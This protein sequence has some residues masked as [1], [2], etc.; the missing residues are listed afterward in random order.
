MRLALSEYTG[1]ENDIIGQ[2]SNEYPDKSANPHTRL[3]H[4][5]ASF[6]FAVEYFR[7]LLP[8]LR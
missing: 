1:H 3:H 5:H 8:D 2:T 7:S 4:V 6:V